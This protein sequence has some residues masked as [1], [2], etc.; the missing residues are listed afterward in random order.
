MSAGGVINI[1]SPAAK[2]RAE[3]VSFGADGH[4]TGQIFG[5][6]GL[7][8]IYA[9]IYSTLFLFLLSIGSIAVLYYYFRTSIFKYQWLLNGIFYTSLIGLGET[10]EH[11]VIN[12]HV[13][14]F[15][16]YLHLIAAPMALGFYLT[17]LDETFNGKGTRKDSGRWKKTAAAF[18]LMLVII[19]VLASFSTSTWDVEIE[20][21]FVLITTLPTLILAG[22]LLE[23][24][25]IISESTLAL[26]SLRVML[27]GVSVLTI[28]I[29]AGRYGDFAR[30]AQVY[31]VFHQLQNMSH[32]VTATA[33]LIFVV[34]VAQ[35]E[36][37]FT[38]A[39]KEMI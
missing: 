17:S 15:F 13:G 8:E 23:R 3:M 39:E 34:T 33:L 18:I 20:V 31:I 28:S 16:H 19:S 11:L 22:V 5:H 27:L 6:H 35:I 26:T 24:S 21:P 14:S 9:H 10:F 7:L 25:K 12:P 29:L 36:K 1:I 30:K 37:L 38:S 32:I 4:L 2:N